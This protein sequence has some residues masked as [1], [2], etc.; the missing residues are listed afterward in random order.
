[1]TRIT[2]TAWVHVQ[3]QINRQIGPFAQI[4]HGQTF[5]FMQLTCVWAIRTRQT[6]RHPSVCS[7]PSLLS[8][9]FS[10]LVDSICIGIGH[11]DTMLAVWLSCC[12]SGQ[13]FE[14]FQ[15]Q[16]LLITHRLISKNQI[17]L[18]GSLE[19]G[20]LWIHISTFHLRTKHCF[21]LLKILAIQAQTTLLYFYIFQ[22]EQFTCQSSCLDR[23]KSSQ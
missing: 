12:F 9:L 21:V 19:D 16:P 15:A 3:Q 5:S 8:C 20:A 7:L 13:R 18:V 22:D 6:G 4:I 23:V 1:M 11:G 2:V 10:G 14:W 17:R